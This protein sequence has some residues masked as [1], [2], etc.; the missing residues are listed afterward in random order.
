MKRAS[1]PRRRTLSGLPVKTRVPARR[2]RGTA[3]RRVVRGP[4]KVRA[5]ENV[6]GIELASREETGVYSET[7]SGLITRMGSQVSGGKRSD[8]V[9][10]ARPPFPTTAADV[11]RLDTRRRAASPDDSRATRERDAFAK[12]AD[13]DAI[14][15]TPAFARRA[16]SRRRTLSSA[17]VSTKRAPPV[18]H[19]S[20]KKLNPSPRLRPTRR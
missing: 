15:S 14:S 17:L 4:A 7:G 12:G 16:R 19:V 18:P 8:R 11:E 20:P 3:R 5:A 10:P 9:K 13:P 6:E 1:R 2:T